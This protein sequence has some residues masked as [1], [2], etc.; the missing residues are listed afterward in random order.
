MEVGVPS[1]YAFLDIARVIRYRFHAD[2]L[3]HD[4]CAATADYAEEDVIRL[5]PLKRN[6]EPEAVTIKRQRGGNISDDKERRDARNFRFSH[7][8]CAGRW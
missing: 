7:I 2:L 4:H 6:V 3:E 1:G 8:F 5:G